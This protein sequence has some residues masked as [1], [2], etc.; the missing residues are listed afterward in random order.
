MADQGFEK[1]HRHRVMSGDQPT[2]AIHARGLLSL[3][4]EA[5]TEMGKPDAVE[6]YFKPSGVGVIG[7]KS[8]T[9]ESPDAYVVRH[10]S[11][12]AHHVEARAFMKFY[13]VSSEARG[14]RYR[15]EMDGDL[16]IVDLNQGAES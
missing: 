16:L 12:T 3:N 9:R 13:D 6:L 7:I 4:M 15:V 10:Q 14:R 1:W 5:W 11:Q 8:A 2:V